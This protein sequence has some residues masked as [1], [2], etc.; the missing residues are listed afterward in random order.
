MTNKDTAEVRIRTLP[1][2]VKEIYRDISY[3]TRTSMEKLY[4]RALTE[5]AERE[6]RKEDE[7]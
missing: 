1:E 4:V 6:S 5:F 3:R 2:D 7:K